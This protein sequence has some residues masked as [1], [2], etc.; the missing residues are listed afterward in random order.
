[1]NEEKEY[2]E[3]S[4]KSEEESDDDEFIR[5]HTENNDDAG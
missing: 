2:E 3:E 1:M 5:L 4:Y